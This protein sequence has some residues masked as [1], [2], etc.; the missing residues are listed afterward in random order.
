MLREK[1]CR[2]FLTRHLPHLAPLVLY[3]RLEPQVSG[4]EVAQLA[5][6]G[7]VDYTSGCTTVKKK[8]TQSALQERQ[9]VQLGSTQKRHNCGEGMLKK[10]MAAALAE[11]GFTEEQV[12]QAL[13]RKNTIEG[14]VDWILSGEMEKLQGPVQET[15]PSQRS[16]PPIAPNELSSRS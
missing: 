1:V 5:Q 13:K 16:N 7:P 10:E 6:T 9:L 4:F 15:P 14:C 11:Q 3:S 2:V 8:K 12:E